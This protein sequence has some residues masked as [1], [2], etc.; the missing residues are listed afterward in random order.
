[1]GEEI[2]TALQLLTNAWRYA[3][4]VKADVWEFAVEIG[5]LHQKGVNNALLRWLEAQRVV[6]HREEITN[7]GENHRQFTPGGG[8]FTDQTCFVITDSGLGYAQAY[9]H[10]LKGESLPASPSGK[11]PQGSF[12]H[13]QDAASARNVENSPHWD[14]DRK[15]LR[16]V[17]RLVKEFKLPSPNQETILMAFEEEKWPARID[18]PLPPPVLGSAKARLNNTIKSLN[19]NQKH[20]LLRFRGDG[21]GEGILWEAISLPDCR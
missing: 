11:I 12:A 15:Q 9:S 18:D 3:R 13:P 5:N 21:T 19:R 17:G 16:V 10:D 2:L 14:C 20:R 4:D 6:D 1:M 7:L 8:R